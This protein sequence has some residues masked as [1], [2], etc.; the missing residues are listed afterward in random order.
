MYVGTEYSPKVYSIIDSRIATASQPHP[1]LAV[2][3]I[4]LGLRNV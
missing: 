4:D 1:V 3:V 2:R